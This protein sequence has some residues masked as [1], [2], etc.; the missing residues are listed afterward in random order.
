[1]YKASTAEGKTVTAGQASGRKDRKA[2]AET[3]KEE[4]R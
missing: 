2:G 3:E 1:M 4:V